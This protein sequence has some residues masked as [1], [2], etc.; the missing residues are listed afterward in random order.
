M[1]QFEELTQKLT[2]LYPEIAD[3]AHAVGLE[4]MKNE[5]EELTARSGADGF[6]DVMESAQKTTQRAANIKYKIAAYERLEN[7]YH[8]AMTLIDLA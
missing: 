4:G 5:L 6:C 7:D 1:L 2:N 3:L 8:D